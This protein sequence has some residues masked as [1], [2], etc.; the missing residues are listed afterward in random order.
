MREL[1]V[2]AAGGKVERLPATVTDG[3]E[4]EVLS[5]WDRELVMSSEEGFK[6]EMI[7]IKK[8]NIHAWIEREKDS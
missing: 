7:V 3:V 8:G 4:V 5:S 2:R 1:D 6:I